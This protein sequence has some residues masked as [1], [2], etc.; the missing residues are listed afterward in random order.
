MTVK[1]AWHSAIGI[2]V[3]GGGLLEHC[4]LL[5]AM[6]ARRAG[7]LMIVIQVALLLVTVHRH[8]VSVEGSRG[9]G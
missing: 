2:K 8:Q 4:L 5:E 6:C 7:L 1:I 9:T 3:P